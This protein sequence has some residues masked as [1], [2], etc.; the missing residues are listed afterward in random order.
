MGTGAT[1]KPGRA[2]ALYFRWYISILAKDGKRDAVMAKVPQDTA[3]L[4]ANP[5]L[6]SSWVELLHI[7]NVLRAVETIGGM[8]AVRELSRKA[9]EEA[10][11]P[12]MNVVES[13][14]KLF[15][16][17]PAIL[18]KRMN[19]LL[20][21]VEGVNYHYTAINDRSGVMEVE[22][23]SGHEI[24]DCVVVTQL[25]VFQALLDSCGVKGVVGSP[26]RLGPNQVR[27]QIQW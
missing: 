2:K 25:P 22:W 11:K 3:A 15:G 5:P 8:P 13:V 19:L 27:F 24:P 17:S 12:Y 26:E 10:R 1:T 21:H 23:V 18:F 6:A 4:I 20:R 14:L 7:E 9:T 16:A